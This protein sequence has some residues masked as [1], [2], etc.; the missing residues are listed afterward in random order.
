[1][2]QR[3][4]PKKQKDVE[5][6]EPS[7]VATSQVSRFHN[8]TI[9]TLSKDI[10]LK[11]VDISVDDRQL[12][13][14][15]DLRIFGGVNYGL[16]G[17]NGVGKSVLLQCIGKGHLIGLPSNVN[18]L[19]VEQLEGVDTQKSVLDLVIESDKETSKLRYWFDQYSNALELGDTTTLAQVSKDHQLEKIRVQYEEAKAK[20]TKR[21][22]ARGAD[23]RRQL[24]EMEQRVREAENEC[25]E[26]DTDYLVRQSQEK[27]NDLKEALEIRD[28]D[29]IES[30]ARTILL[31]LGFS[32]TMIDSPVGR[33]SGGWR[34]RIA[35]ASALLINPDV[36]LLDEPTNHLDIPMIIWLQ[37]YLKNLNDA[38]IIVISHDRA[39]LNEVT[40]E[41]IVFKDRQLSYFAGNYDEYREHFEEHQNFLKEKKDIME[42][43]KAN[44]EKSARMEMAKAKK[45][46]DDKKMAAVASKQRKMKDGVHM[47]VNEKG[48]K[49][50]LNR[51][52]PGFHHNTR[53][54]IVLDSHDTPQ[55]WTLENPSPLRNSGDIITVE[56]V[57]FSYGKNDKPI[58]QNV[59][60]SIPQDARVGIIGANGV[61][62]TTF[63]KLLMDKLIPTQG[64]IQRH[65]Q[66][67]IGYFSQHHVDDILNQANSDETM[68]SFLCSDGN[69]ISEQEARA[70]LGRFGI[71]GQTSLSP[72]NTLS[73]GE[74]VRLAFAKMT[75]N[76]SPH[77]LILDEPTNHLDFLTIESFISCLK[78]FKGAVI[79]A[80]HDQKFIAETCNKIYMVDKTKLKSIES[81]DRYVNIIRKRLYKK[82]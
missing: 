10:D 40:D 47:D 70:Q 35:L 22:G 58:L 34:I 55:K 3:R 82:K 64:M 14:D 72:I 46:G 68:V 39:F 15:A 61:G 80:S 21:S 16:V 63:L 74:L 49:F 6:L 78:N 5:S 32:E 31:G 81:V 41:T 4:K 75:L 69:H 11:G 65:S 27:L 17:Q 36:L 23:A 48:H 38:S 50:K 33:L 13:S 26:T 66:A 12:L 54:D 1:M 37:D 71:K 42:K 30:R 60:T 8:E 29:S 25:L 76:A 53:P 28:A 44:A 18:A 56:D 52:R 77:L 24:N 7:I 79:V 19:Y 59:T 51:D 2:K 45:S 67:T 9:E 73:G 43:Q 57:S 20:A 62:K